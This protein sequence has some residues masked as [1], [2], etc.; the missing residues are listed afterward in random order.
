MIFNL[1]RIF[2]FYKGNF[3]LINYATYQKFPRPAVSYLTIFL[4]QQN[5]ENKLGL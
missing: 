3:K 2:I 1:E 4:I 5:Y